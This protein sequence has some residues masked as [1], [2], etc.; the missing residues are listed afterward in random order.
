MNERNEE[1]GYLLFQKNFSSIGI[2]NSVTFIKEA[3]RN[4][5]Q[6]QRTFWPF[7]SNHFN[8]YGPIA[9]NTHN[10]PEKG[11]SLLV[12]MLKSFGFQDLYTDEGIKL[13]QVFMKNNFKSGNGPLL[14]HFRNWMCIIKFLDFFLLPFVFCF[15]CLSPV[16]IIAQICSVE[17]G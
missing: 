2:V 14:L 11:N 6:I 16:L 4:I 9:Y 17:V 13:E 12:K 3:L 15:P 10:V 8:M 1:V 7:I 5:S